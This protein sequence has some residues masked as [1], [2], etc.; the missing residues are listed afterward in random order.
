MSTENPTVSDSNPTSHES[1]HRQSIKS[2]AE[3]ASP[4]AQEVEP[5]AAN[6]A[7]PEEAHSEPQ[8]SVSQPESLK[9]FLKKTTLVQKLRDKHL[10]LR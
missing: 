8:P 9:M 7:T 6:A 2:A 3:G 4:I 5:G 10:W 1:T